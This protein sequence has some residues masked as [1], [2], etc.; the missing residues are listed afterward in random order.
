MIENVY[1]D[2]GATGGRDKQMILSPAGA[3]HSAPSELIVQIGIRTSG[4]TG[5]YSNPSP[6]E[7]VPFERCSFGANYH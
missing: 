6:A 3:L 1:K 4:C 7:K 5:G 2:E